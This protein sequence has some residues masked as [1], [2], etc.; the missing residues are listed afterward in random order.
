VSRASAERAGIRTQAGIAGD[1][2]TR[3]P[4]RCRP[5]VHRL[6]GELLRH[7]HHLAHVRHRQPLGHRAVGLLE[8]SADQADFN[9]RQ[10]ILQVDSAA[11]QIVAQ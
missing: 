11:R 9:C 6:L 8:R 2:G 5:A 7:R 10:M 1:K 4:G 3:L